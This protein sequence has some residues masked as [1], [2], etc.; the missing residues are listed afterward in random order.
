[1]WYNSGWINATTASYASLHYG[2][3]AYT[4]PQGL[5]IVSINTDFWYVD[6][7]FN[8]YVR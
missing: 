8:Y 1:L 6:N 4:T 3:Y 2:A 5:K 7:I